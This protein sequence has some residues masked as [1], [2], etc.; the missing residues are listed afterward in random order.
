[1][2]SG[3]GSPN[4]DPETP[5]PSFSS[6]ADPNLKHLRGQIKKVMIPLLIKIFE[7]KLAA[8]AA[9][10]PPSRLQKKMHESPEEIFH[11]LDQI[12]SD[13]KLL[14]LWCVSCQKQLEKAKKEIEEI[15]KP[16]QLHTSEQTP[17]P[18]IGKSFSEAVRMPPREDTPTISWLKKFLQK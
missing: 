10:T 3:L 11:Q 9:K 13:L 7:L 4:S 8:Q 17:N 2:H 1:M 18:A 5:P 15:G 16:P 14:N 12:E 6:V